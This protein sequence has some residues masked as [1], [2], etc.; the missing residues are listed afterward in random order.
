MA[1][2]CSTRRQSDRGTAGY[3]RADDSADREN[4]GTTSIDPLRR[5]RTQPFGKVYV[6]ASTVPQD[7]SAAL[8][9]ALTKTFV[10]KEFLADAEKGK[11]EIAPVSAQQAQKLVTD[12]LGLSPDL[13][14]KLRKILKP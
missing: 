12:F 9:A 5:R 4:R 10:D 13:K 2:S 7:R 11:L 3:K 6:V 8:E 1:Y 14:A